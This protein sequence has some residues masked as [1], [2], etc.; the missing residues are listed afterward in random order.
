MPYFSDCA[1]QVACGDSHTLILSISGLLYACG[2]NT[3]GQLGT[4]SSENSNVC[5]ILE[6]VSGIPMQEIAAS[7]FSAAV[8]EEEN[9]LYVWGALNIKQPRRFK[10]EK[11]TKV[12]LG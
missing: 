5:T 9:N 12:S 7:N 2:L 3:E 10:S 4:N 11:L 1:K 8:C 6:S